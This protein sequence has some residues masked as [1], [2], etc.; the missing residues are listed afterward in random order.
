MSLME[1]CMLRVFFHNRKWSNTHFCYLNKSGS[2]CLKGTGSNQIGFKKRNYGEENSLYYKTE[3]PKVENSDIVIQIT[4]S[5]VTPGCLSQLCVRLWLRSWSYSLWV[6]APHWALGWQAGACFRFCVS[7][8]LCPSPI[9]T[10]CMSLS[11]KN[12]QTLTNYK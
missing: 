1:K 12:K 3:K 6:W 5:L 2:F 10:H 7:L 4:F 8:S 9:R 11:L